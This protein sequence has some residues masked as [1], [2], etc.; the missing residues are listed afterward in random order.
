M[1]L[2]KYLKNYIYILFF[3]VGMDVKLNRKDT[4]LTFVTTGVFL[5]KLIGTKSLR[6]WTHIIIDEVHERDL[7]TDLLLLII[8]QILT[9]EVGNQVRIILM[10]ATLDTTQFS[11]YFKIENKMDEEW[12]L[13]GAPVLRIPRTELS[14]PVREFYIDDDLQLSVSGL[15]TYFFSSA[16]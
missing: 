5:Q 12:D 13:D 6:D 3:Q 11:N 4:L 9:N 8:K 2:V 14:F 10:S 15:L 7:E 1:R 16:N